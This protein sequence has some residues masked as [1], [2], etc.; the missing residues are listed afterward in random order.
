MP[1]LERRFVLTAV[2]RPLRITISVA[3][4]RRTFAPLRAALSSKALRNAAHPVFFGSA[5]GDALD[6]WGIEDAER[7]TAG[8][9]VRYRSRR[10]LMKQVE[11]LRDTDIHSFKIAAMERTIA[12]PVDPWISL[13]DP[14]LLLAMLFAIVGLA[15]HL[16][17]TRR[18]AAESIS[19]TDRGI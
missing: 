14:R 12:F 2:T 9:L 13:G 5:A 10:D 19:E 17:S 18:Q 6:I 3:R 7:W 11:N 15:Y 16:R 1:R 8:G 4:S